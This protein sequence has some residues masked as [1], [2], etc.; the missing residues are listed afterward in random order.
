[1][2]V[3]VCVCVRARAKDS[4]RSFSVNIFG[5]HILCHSAT[6]A[7]GLWAN[8]SVRLPPQF[9]THRRQSF[10][11]CILQKNFLLQFTAFH[12]HRSNDK[13]F[14]GGYRGRNLEGRLLHD[15]L[16]FCPG[17]KQSQG[18]GVVHHTEK[19]I[20]VKGPVHV[21]TM[22]VPNQGKRTQAKQTKSSLPLWGSTKHR[23]SQSRFCNYRKT[24]GHD[25]NDDDADNFPQGRSSRARPKKCVQISR[26][27]VM[28]AFDGAA[29]LHQSK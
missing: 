3:C 2:C 5:L 10:Y 7:L 19:K 23:D 12:V 9:R 18:H 26:L 8:T 21:Y 25:D 13:L 1:M 29:P 6:W 22:S 24:R 17:I 20:P 28:C 14:N 11:R 16:F 15:L 4:P 27:L